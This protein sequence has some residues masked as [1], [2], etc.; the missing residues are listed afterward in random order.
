MATS[1]AKKETSAVSA[2]ERA[3]GRAL[4]AAQTAHENK[5]RDIQILDLRELTTEFDYF[6][7]ATGG[8][9]RQ[10]HAISEEIDHC[11]E[12]DLHDRR[13][14]LEGYQ[15]GGWILQDYGDI[16]IHLFDAKTR[17][18]YRLDEL[19]TGAKRVPFTPKDPA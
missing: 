18:Y 11:L 10:L 3:L 5:G 19:W 7:I 15:T 6:V 12:D 17:E 13:L 9:T 2:R 4:A 16:V 14:G 8:S 1:S